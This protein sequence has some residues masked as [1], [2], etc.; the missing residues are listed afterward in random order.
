VIGG[1]V[2]GAF[3]PDP[4]RYY[5]EGHDRALC[6]NNPHP[7]GSDLHKRWLAGFRSARAK[8]MEHAPRVNGGEK[9]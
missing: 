5:P 2:K 8:S 1:C 6:V 9:T 4:E 3:P 7:N